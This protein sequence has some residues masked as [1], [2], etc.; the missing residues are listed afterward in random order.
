MNLTEVKQSRNNDNVEYINPATLEDK[1]QVYSL[2]HFMR[3][4]TREDKKLVLKIGRYKKDKI[5]GIFSKS[6]TPLIENP[7]SEL[8]LS[9]IELENLIKY[10]SEN[11]YPLQNNEIKYLTFDDEAMY[12]LIKE[13]PENISK[14]IEIAISKNLDL[15][16]VNKLI[17]ISDRRKALDEFEQ[18]YNSNATE[19]LWQKWFQKNNW[20]FGSD[21]ISIS[22]DRRIDVEHIADFIVKN[23]DGFVDVIEI[24]RPTESAI[25][26]ES[27]KDHGNLIPSQSLTKAITQLVNYLS[28]LEKKANNIDTTKRVGKILKPRGI[29]IYGNSKNWN[30]E[31]YE[32][33]RLLN[34]SLTNV[35]ILTYNMVFNRAK[36]MNEY[37]SAK[38]TNNSEEQR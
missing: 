8:T 4:K 28:Q 37:L 34:D 35:S 38:R 23:L 2:A 26:F 32:S 22:E 18:L 3:I 21:F 36:K 16:D 13:K 9:T 17:E 29:L 19:N 5:F 14:L 31:K 33:F 1:K 30:E 27:N 6:G 10:I 20:V 15:S 24:K 12:A 11:Y 25:F 7:K